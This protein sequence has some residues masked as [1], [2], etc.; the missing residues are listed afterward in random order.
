MSEC[1]TRSQMR[2][3]LWHYRIA[4][5]GQLP[6]PVVTAWWRELRGHTAAQVQAALASVPAQR[7][8]RVSA[9]EVAQLV[10]LVAL[11][12]Q[13]APGSARPP[14]PVAEPDRVRER[15]RFAVAGQRGIRAVY[16]AMGWTRPPEAEQAGRVRCP[17][18][19]AH[20]GRVCRPITRT[21]D[22]RREHRDPDTRMHP[23]RLAAARERPGAAAPARG[24][25]GHGAV[26]A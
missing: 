16:S 10:Q 13:A 18:C 9:E 15:A 4:G 26:S 20:A 3:L 19:W 24:A 21:R 1:L 25:A 14:L 7:V 12:P 5:E 17:Y 22:G 2:A 11:A 8:G 6:E 23:S